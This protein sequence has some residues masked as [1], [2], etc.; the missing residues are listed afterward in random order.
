MRNDW[1]AKV[2]RTMTS[3]LPVSDSRVG[4]CRRCGEC[5]KL[6]TKCAFLRYD[7]QGLASCAIHKVRP[8]NCRKYP[9]TDREHITKE[10]CGYGW[11]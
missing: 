5:C 10:G 3:P 1:I 2:I 11:N 7:E 8:L 9:R 6:P 4:E